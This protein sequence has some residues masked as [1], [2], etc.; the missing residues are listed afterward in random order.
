MTHNDLI[1]SSSFIRME[2]SPSYENSNLLIFSYISK[3]TSSQKSS[4]TATH[5]SLTHVHIRTEKPSE[6]TCNKMPSVHKEEKIFV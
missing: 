1:E 5:F 2:R 3:E 6:N 4:L